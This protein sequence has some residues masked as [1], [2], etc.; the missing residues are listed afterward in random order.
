MQSGGDKCALSDIEAGAPPA[1]VALDE[2]P[3]VVVT[4]DAVA[5][6]LDESHPSDV[7]MARSARDAD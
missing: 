1:E 3:H 2:R 7:G 5:G 4:V 6:S